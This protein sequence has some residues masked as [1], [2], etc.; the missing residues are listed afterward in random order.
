[1]LKPVVQ[2][3]VVFL[4]CLLGETIVQL[5]S[6]SFPSSVISMV[7]LFL[8]L[9]LK[10]IRQENIQGMIQFLQQNMALF[11]IPSGVAI[12]ENYG[13]LSDSLIPFLLICI[14]STVVTFAATAYTVRLVSA[15]QQKS[16][17]SKRKGERRL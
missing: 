16:A 4:I 17:E 8:F 7:I 1:M 15:L 14:I 5:F 6:L 3:A 10:W 11:F 13:Y 9:V 2:S 12:M